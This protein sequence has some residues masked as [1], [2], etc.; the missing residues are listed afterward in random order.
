MDKIHHLTI[1]EIVTKFGKYL[2]KKEC[3]LLTV[4]TTITIDNDQIII[5][6]NP[7]FSKTDISYE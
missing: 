3:K 4:N 5:I 6:S 2:T 7:K 1:P